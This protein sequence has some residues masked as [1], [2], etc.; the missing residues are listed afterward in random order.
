MNPILQ[1]AARQGLPR[2]TFLRNLL[3][4]AGSVPAA[5]MLTACGSDSAP[6][7]LRNNPVS[8]SGRTSPFATMG[9]L[10]PPDENGVRLPAGFTSRV[11]AVVNEPPLASNPDFRWHSDPDGAGM[12]RTEDGGWIY[13]SNSEA[14]D[15]TTL[16]GQIP[17]TPVISDLASRDSLA[18]LG[19]VTGPI[20]GLLP[21]SVP[22]VLPF[23]GGASALRFDKNGTLVDAYPIQRNTTT[24]CSGGATPWGTWIN[25][26][27][28]VDGYMFE[29][30]PLKDGGTPIRLDRFG[31]KAHEQVAIDVKRRIIYHTEDITGEDR[32]Y[33]TIFSA[34]DWP[35][36]GKPDYSKGVLQVL[37][38]DAGVDAAKRGPTPVRWVNA[39]DDG[40]PQFKVYQPDTTV[41]A[42]NEGVWFLNDFVFFTTK[43]DSNVWAIDTVGGTI[44]SIYNPEDGPVGS[45]VDNSEPPM[46]GVDNI[47]VT[48]DGEMVVV[49]DGGDM[50]AMVLLPDRSTIPLVRLPGDPSGTEVTGPA[51]SPDGR[52]LYIA[53][54]RALPDG[55]TTNFGLGGTIYEITMPFSVRVDPPLARRL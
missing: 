33:R 36:G 14:R 45:P 49:E 39:V 55:T 31:R 32:F 54:Q 43:G 4:A 17:D 19:T 30:S 20:T 44:E 10:L 11:V 27:E 22:L 50:R 25:G 15:A 42:G 48:L 40:T 18:V 24:N 47:C 3:M 13:V 35:E 12:F 52:R 5:Q 46:I 21:V 7:G 29:A 8:P 6:S 51:F 28:I 38:V 23:Q 16:F 37:A 26:E 53:N 2:R 41:F 9:P 1:D 34:A